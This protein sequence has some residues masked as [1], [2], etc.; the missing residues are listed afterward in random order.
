MQL[1]E[2]EAH[3]W[4]LYQNNDQYFMSVAVDM[5]SVISCWDLCLTDEEITGYQAF[6][7]ESIDAL[8]K[9][10]I[11]MA[12]KGDFS[13]LESRLAMK[14]DQQAMQSSYRIWQSSQRIG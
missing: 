7:R 10:F 9:S 2:H 8:A 14:D 3:F 1:I 4:E 12:Y 11:A 5:S 13:N 6:G